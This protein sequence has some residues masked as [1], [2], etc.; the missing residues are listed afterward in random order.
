MKVAIETLRQYGYVL[1]VNLSMFTAGMNLGWPSPMLVKLMSDDTPLSRPLTEDEGSWVVSVGFLCAAVSSLGLGVLLDTLG[2]KNSILLGCLFKVFVGLL[3]LFATEVWMLILGRAIGTMLE[4]IMFCGVPIYASEIANK[5]QRGA[6]GVSLAMFSALGMVVTL[7]VGPYT[8]YVT[9]NTILT[10]LI[11]VTSIPLLFVPE[12][13]YYLYSKGRLEDSIKVLTLIRGTDAL[14]KEEL[15]GY[16]NV[17]RSKVDV[18][19]LAL[20]KNATFRKSLALSLMLGM[21]SQIIGS[22]AVSFYLQT[23]LE[24]T[25]VSVTAEI[26]SVIAGVIQFTGGFTATPIARRFGRKPILTWS[27]TGYALGM[28][29]LGI[30]FKIT[31]AEDYVI[32]GFLNYLPLLSIVVVIYGY[33]VGIG[34]L[35]FI[36]SAEL[37]DDVSRA[38]GV[39]LFLS[40]ATLLVF[41]MTKYFFLL[42]TAM[43]PAIT[44][45]V[46]S[47]VTVLLIISISM[48]LPETKGK[49][50]SE[51]QNA[52]G[53]KSGALTFFKI[54]VSTLLVKMRISL[55]SPLLRQYALVA[56]VNFSVFTSGIS[57]AWPS[58]ILVK[59]NDPE[60]T[61]LSRSITSE[62]GSWIVSVGF[63]FAI[64]TDILFARLLDIIGRRYSLLLLSI[65]KLLVGLLYIFATEPWMLIVG[66]L[67]MSSADCYTLI[68]AP[69]YASELASKEH[70]GVLGTLLQVFASSGELVAYSIGPF[71]SYRTFN[72]LFTSI[73]LISIFPVAFFLPDS[74]S[75][76]YSKDRKEESLKVLTFLR[77]DN[78][79]ATEEIEEYKCVKNL[80]AKKITL[81]KDSIFRKSLA[82]AILIAAGTQLTGFNAVTFYLQTILITTNTSV[83]SEIASVVIGVIQVVSSSL[84]HVIISS[85]MKVKTILTV[86]LAAMCVGMIGLGVFFKISE[87]EDYVVTR[88]M[89][90]LP[91]ISLVVVI[92]AYQTGIGPL[93]WLVIGELF[94]DSARA[95]GVSVALTSS[96]TLMFLTS[97]YFPFVT[98]NLG[99]PATYWI[100]S[101]LNALLVTLIAI[102]LPETKGKSFSEIQ[103]ALGRK[104]DEELPLE[105]ITEKRS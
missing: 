69:I 92:S 15:E 85:R 32:E 38:F 89:N 36:I 14:V 22:S 17:Q 105:T 9:F 3:L 66:R 42:V 7:S 62:E 56:I 58:P 2:R 11:V 78:K 27:L 35:Y 46:F 8:S 44:Y 67:F 76:L 71:V 97:K 50:F 52:L 19:K 57:F 61:P 34:S 13:P 102:F 64:F 33:N 94:E 24:S 103:K 53:L 84:T 49:S 81:L 37:F 96:V 60:Q 73:I 54:T 65:P 88:F 10:T 29:S 28:A 70:R 21:G 43:G 91:L 41:I 63:L 23:I 95:F 83:K 79:R 74:P 16:E 20:L 45:W 100:F 93:I 55:S 59:L 25:G 6:L 75:Y 26:S 40:T 98:E 47:G 101:G 87:L 104:I 18:N 90:Y 1:I 77:G 31:E 51:I 30:F 72:I 39:S 99:P 12:S 4:F 82:L 48:F 68:I 5:K 86:S 80:S